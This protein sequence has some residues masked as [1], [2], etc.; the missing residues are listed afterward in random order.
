MQ[1][2]GIKPE[3]KVGAVFG[4]LALVFSFI[5][6]LLAG[7]RFAHAAVMSL[8]LAAVFAGIGFGV[9]EV[10]RRFVPE[11]YE[12]LSGLGL[13]RQGAP[14]EMVAVSLEGKENAEASEPA[15]ERVSSAAVESDPEEA[16]GESY[17]GPQP[18][19]AQKAD[20]SAAFVPLKEK[21]FA[22]VGA[23]AQEG[24]L[25]KHI[26]EEKKIRYEPKIIA[27][28]IRTMISRDKE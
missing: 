19:E 26:L 6:S 10:L 27:E 2:S 4:V 11:L 8:V 25:G 15:V 1:L 14:E 17:P 12:A 23:Q 18:V 9:I 24:K 16:A 5:T 28:A 13:S 3:H 21:D 7:N 20:T 22:R